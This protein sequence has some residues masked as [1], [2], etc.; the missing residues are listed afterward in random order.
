MRKVDNIVIRPNTAVRF[1]HQV[2]NY[3]P[4]QVGASKQWVKFTAEVGE[5]MLDV[6]WADWR[7]SFGDQALRAMSMGVSDFC[8]IRMDYQPELY[9]LLRTK[10]ML[11][12]KDA[13]DDAIIDGAPVQS[14]ELLMMFAACTGSWSSKSGDLKRNDRYYQLTA[15]HTG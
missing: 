2:T 1:Y 7:G 14:G 8:T 15:N 13:N 4:G 3:N 11:V 9:E 12:V 5:N 6:F 10:E